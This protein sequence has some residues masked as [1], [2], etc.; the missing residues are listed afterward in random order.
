V[1]SK[2]G[3]AVPSPKPIP[4]YGRAAAYGLA[5]AVGGGAAW[6]AL[7]ALTGIYTIIMAAA[8]G[9]LCGTSV[10]RGMG[11]VTR[12][13]I[14][15]SFYF[16]ALMVFLGEYFLFAW[17]FLGATGRL[18]PAGAFGML[19]GYYQ[20]DILRLLITLL[21]TLTGMVVSLIYSR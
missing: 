4:N 9:W 3:N 18:S 14:G 7:Q 12:A 15:L 1:Q 21:F 16:T 8:A 13:G 20:A 5:A 19:A 17:Y 10:K 11:A 2:K 6:A